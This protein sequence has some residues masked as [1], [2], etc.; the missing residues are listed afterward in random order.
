MQKRTFLYGF[1]CGFAVMLF[2]ASF[3]PVE[4]A[5]PPT[6]AFQN[7]NITLPWYSGGSV[8]VES[9]SSSDTLYLVSDGSITFNVTESYP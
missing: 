9:E 2:L 8:L 7:F 6:R 1:V 3:E 4:S 5:I